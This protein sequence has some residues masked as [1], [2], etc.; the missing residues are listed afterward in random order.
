MI[1]ALLAEGWIL[2]AANSGG[3]PHAALLVEHAVVVVGPLTPDFLVAPVG[4][5]LHRLCGGGGVE[6]WSKRFGSVRIRDWHLEK[7]HRVRLGIEDRHVVAR[8]FIR[9]IE[10]TVSIDG[11]M[12]PVRR[13]QVVNKGLLC[14]PLPRGDDDVALDTLGARRFGPGQL[15]VGDAVGP[16]AEKL[17]RPAANL[18]GDS[19]HHKFARLAGRVR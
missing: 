7:R 9:A 4:R 18:Y 8:V 15:A 16:V 5:G 10:R 3:K 12:A 19:G 11:R 14:T 6:G 1:R 13:D 2:D 17:E